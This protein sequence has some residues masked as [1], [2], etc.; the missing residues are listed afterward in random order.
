MV[1]LFMRRG[2]AGELPLSIVA[3]TRFLFLWRCGSG[4]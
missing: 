1:H 2:D 3:A 4:G